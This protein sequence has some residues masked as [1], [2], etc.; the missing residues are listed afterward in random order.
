LINTFATRND[1]SERSFTH[2]CPL[3]TLVRGTVILGSSALT[4]FRG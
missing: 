1:A 2:L 4:G 3:C